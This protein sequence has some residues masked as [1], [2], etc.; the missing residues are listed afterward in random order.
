MRCQW[1]RKHY[2][3]VRKSSISRRIRSRIQKGFSPWIRGP[4]G[5]VWWKNPKVENLVTLSL[6]KGFKLLSK[7]SWNSFQI[8]RHLNS[9]FFLD[10]FCTSSTFNLDYGSGNDPTFTPQ[11]QGPKQT[12][13]DMN[14][15]L[16]YN[17]PLVLCVRYVQVLYCK[18]RLDYCVFNYYIFGSML[19]TI[20]LHLAFTR[21]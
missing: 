6:K 2:F 4:E 12:L 5:I 11:I 17:I 3:C 18:V 9:N 7:A 10:N 21:R 8:I 16:Q 15:I 13:E 19:V 1:H 20:S 14:A